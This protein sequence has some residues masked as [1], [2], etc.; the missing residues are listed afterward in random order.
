MQDNTDIYHLEEVLVMGR[1]SEH[2]YMCWC[3]DTPPTPMPAKVDLPD[4]PKFWRQPQHYKPDLPELGLYAKYPAT[5]F[6]GPLFHRLSDEYIIIEPCQT[7]TG[8]FE[9]SRDVMNMC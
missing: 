4:K 1:N 7:W 8:K 9:L 3:T 6:T 2:Y 5:A